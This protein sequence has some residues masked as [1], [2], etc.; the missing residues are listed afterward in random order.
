[1][2]VVLAMEIANELREAGDVTYIG[3]EVLRWKIIITNNV[4]KLNKLARVKTK[5]GFHGK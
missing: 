5:E 2:D 1:M 3:K 4:R